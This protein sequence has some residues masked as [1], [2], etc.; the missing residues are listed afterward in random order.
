MKSY[1]D[2]ALTAALT[3][4]L[5]DKGARAVG[6]LTALR[7]LDLTYCRDVTDEGMRAVVSSCTALTSLNLAGC[8]RLTDAGLRALS[9]LPANRSRPPPLLQGDGS[10]AGAPQQHRR[11]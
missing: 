7:F 5:T 9:S 10:R 2:T 11:P 6:S 3:A 4:A 1:G 8:N